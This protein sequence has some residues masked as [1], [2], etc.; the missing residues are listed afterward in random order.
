MGTSGDTL[1]I[2][3]DDVDVREAVAIFFE[4]EGY[5]VL[6]AANGADALAMLRSTRGVCL[7]LLDLFMPIMDAW[8]FRR[9]QLADP[10]L[11]AV[12][13][14]VITA[15]HLASDQAKALGARGWH[16]KPIDFDRLMADVDAYC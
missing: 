11:A 16:T 6:Q 3:E 12:P 1:L 13:V 5:E 8:A 7:I 4:A 9:A 10:E 15:D 14:I 2:V